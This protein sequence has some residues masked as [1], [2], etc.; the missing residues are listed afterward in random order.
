[1]HD[2]IF[3]LSQLSILVKGGL[4]VFRHRNARLALAEALLREI[5]LNRAL[6][7]EAKQ[8]TDRSDSAFELPILLRSMQLN[9]ADLIF[10]S[11]Y[12]ISRMFSAKW[13]VPEDGHQYIPYL[14]GCTESAD[15]I[16]KAV[17]R[18][19]ILQL[20]AANDLLGKDRRLD[21]AGFLL[22]EAEAVIKEYLSSNKRRRLGWL[23]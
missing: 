16:E 20:L 9:S 11:G 6:I 13:H 22:R 4:A 18:V 5:R 14:A 3:L 7:L 2:P 1:M 8:L 23:G 21:Y 10:G 19:N 17:H 15:V 12:P